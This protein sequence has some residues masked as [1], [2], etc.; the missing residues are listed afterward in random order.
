MSGDKNNIEAR[1]RYK[2]VNKEA[3]EQTIESL[4]GLSPAQKGFLKKR[5]LHQVLWWDKRAR[6]SR[7]KYYSCRA[8]AAIGSVILPALVGL[9]GNDA[10]NP[11]T[12]WITFALGLTV[13][14]S[15]AINGLFH[16]GDV[17][18][19][20]RDATELLKIEGWLFFQ[21]SGKYKENTYA[22]A[23]PAFAEQVEFIIEREIKTYIG[24]LQDNT[25]DDKINLPAKELT[26]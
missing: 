8:I 16:F 9:S 1:S 2:L 15:I 4:E 5:W 7:W 12:K 23:F 18:R 22:T 3:L 14:I 25:G 26:R 19:E 21:L 17:W 20:K 24:V 13:A 6:E 11:Y 10:V